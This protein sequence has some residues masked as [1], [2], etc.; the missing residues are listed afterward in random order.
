[1]TAPVIVG[2]DGG[3][4][5][6]DALA[7][8]RWLAGAQRV[9]LIVAVVHPAPS[10]IGS[11]RV[12]AEWVAD[13]HRAAERILAGARAA[14][15]DTPGVDYRV[16]ASTS[17]A[18]GLH[19]LAEQTGAAMLVV[20]SGASAPAARI[21]A[22]STAQRLLAGSVCPIAVTPA[23]GGPAPGT[24]GR[25]GVAYVDT[26][27]GRVALAAAADLARRTGNPLLLVTVVAGG[28]AALPFLI[29][30][31]AERAFLETARE[32]YEEALRR[33]AATVPD[34]PVEW[35]LR[36]GDVVQQL[37]GLDE[38]DV[39][40]CG[41]RGYGPARRVLLGGVSGRLLRRAARPLVVAPRA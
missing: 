7:L 33:A 5:A 25:I 41:S 13:R 29:G 10:A 36:S 3:P 15:D 14:L 1:M 32:T 12:D 9:P 37:A 11:G 26:P 39:L 31:D 21:L 20:G 22:G 16:V 19:D 6:A 24:L 28:D 2:T 40:F 30:D 18:H 34:V 17:A 35:Q 27:D 38:V 23:G 4:G 8:G